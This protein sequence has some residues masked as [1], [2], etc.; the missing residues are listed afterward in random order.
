MVSSNLS[1]K[2]V[3]ISTSRISH[4]LHQ[5][6]PGQGTMFARVEVF[7][8]EANDAL[9]KALLRVVMTLRLDFQQL[10]LRKTQ[11]TKERGI[12]SSNWWHRFQND[13]NIILNWKKWY[14]RACRVVSPKMLLI[15]TKVMIANS[16]QFLIYLQDKFNITIRKFLWGTGTVYAFNQTPTCF[17]RQTKRGWLSNIIQQLWDTKFHI[18]T[19]QSSKLA[20]DS[21]PRHQSLLKYTPKLAMTKV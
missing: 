6:P 7:L 5:P 12:A 8:Q 2:F 20:Q 11:N 4:S 9:L 18:K 10:W 19:Y 21:L 15:L 17:L 14:N 1:C 13:R 16:S 3:I